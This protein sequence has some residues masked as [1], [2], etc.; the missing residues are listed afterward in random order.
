MNQTDKYMKKYHVL[1]FVLVF[2]AGSAYYVQQYS[3]ESAA[4]D[5]VVAAATSAPPVSTTQTA[6]VAVPKPQKVSKTPPPPSPE[7]KQNV[8]LLVPGKSYGAYAGV[9]SSTLDVMRSLASTSDFTFTGKEYPSL[10]FFVESINGKAAERGFVWIFYV[11]G[12]EAQKGISQTM[13]S[14]GDTVEWKYED[15]Y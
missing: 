13:L 8:T 3:I 9:G 11:N 7:Q 4:I 12:K 1:A 5:P 14:S 6:S 2:L 10:G 15:N